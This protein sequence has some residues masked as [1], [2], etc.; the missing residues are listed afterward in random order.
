[1]SVP[2]FAHDESDS[3]IT[4][5]GNSKNKK[6]FQEIRTRIQNSDSLTFSNEKTLEIF[7]ELT[8]FDLGRFLLENKGLN[9]Y[10][11]SYLILHGVNTKNNTSLERWLIEKAPV[12]VA[13]R[14]RF[15]IFQKEIQKRLKP[16]MKV[17]SIPC[18]VM[19]DLLTLGNQNIPHVQLI[20][21][22]LDQGSLDLAHKN[23]VHHGLQNDAKFFKEGAWQLKHE[24]EFD[25]I[26]SNGLNIYEADDGKVIELYSN[27][28]KELKPG[29]ILITSFLTPPPMLSNESTWRNLNP[30]DLRKQ[31]A[32]FGDII[33]VTWQ[34]F[35]T[36]EQTRNQLESAGLRVIDVIYDKCGLFPTV[37]AQKD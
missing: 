2:L 16:G 36:E 15:Y 22:D 19:D 23:A 20:G 33:Q 3:L 25:I 9:G 10:W 11:T 13:T 31:K 7:D 21:I 29:G 5:Q 18:G 32:L 30:S 17:A 1:M 14:E 26:V 24:G 27:F 34:S 35:R 12:V 8:T 28:N 37:V 6:S 4:H